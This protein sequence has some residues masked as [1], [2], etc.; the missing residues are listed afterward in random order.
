MELYA[1]AALPLQKE[2]LAPV[3][4]E[5]G[6]ALEPA[7]SK[8]CTYFLLLSTWFIENEAKF[9]LIVTGIFFFCQVP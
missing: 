1:S 6:C 8:Q 3:E 2:P 5:V 9:F 7:W 4:E